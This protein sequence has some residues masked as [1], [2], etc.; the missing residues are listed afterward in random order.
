LRYGWDKPER[1]EV[2]KCLYGVLGD[3]LSPTERASITRDFFRLRSCEAV[4]VTR[5]AGKGQALAR[6]VEI[7]GLEYIEAALAGG[8][9]AILCTAHFGSFESS[10]SLLGARGLPITV[11]GR[12]VESNSNQSPIELFLSQ[13]IYRGFLERHRHRPN[14]EPREG[15][16][17]VAVQTAKILRQNE[18]IGTFI[19]PP[20]LGADHA[21]AIPMDFLNGKIL[22]LP[23]AT[24]I[25]QLIGAPVLMM[26]M[27]RSSDWQH[28]VLEISPPV[29]LNGD[30]V[31]AFR[32]CLAMVES[33]I[34]QNPAHWVF[35]EPKGLVELGLLPEEAMKAY[36]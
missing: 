19:D 20:A 31:T 9:G 12:W 10:F 34:R 11:L 15:R 6:Q 27:R 22:L 26:F 16:F 4:D 32:R 23:G 29:P 8:K 33:A 30:A 21:R 25:A 17:E 14:I 3:Q 7:R 28:Q 2:M 13:L 24:T 18:L 36:A 5:L 1:E 35:W